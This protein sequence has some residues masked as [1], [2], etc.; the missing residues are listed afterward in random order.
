[1]H[2]LKLWIKIRSG[3]TG[4]MT[5][6]IKNHEVLWQGMCGREVFYTWATEIGRWP[7]YVING[8]L[9][10]ICIH[11]SDLDIEDNDPTLFVLKEWIGKGHQL[12]NAKDTPS[13]LEEHFSVLRERHQTQV[14]P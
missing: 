3:D 4:L 13:G 11:N 1:M 6:W 12:P 10:T 5:L 2:G 14:L 8:H 9:C 7:A